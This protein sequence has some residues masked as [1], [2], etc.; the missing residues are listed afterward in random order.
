MFINFIKVIVE[1]N[2]K[3]LI[4]KGVVRSDEVRY[5]FAKGSQIA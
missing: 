1:E 3:K 4:V 5:V 2:G